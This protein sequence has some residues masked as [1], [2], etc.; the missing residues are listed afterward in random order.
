M[1]LVGYS[2]PG[3]GWVHAVFAGDCAHADIGEDWDTHGVVVGV[4]NAGD[5]TILP[6]IHADMDISAVL[7]L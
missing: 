6:A 3:A 7:L 5:E 2:V 4:F 1:G